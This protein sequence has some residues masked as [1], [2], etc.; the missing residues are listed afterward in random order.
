MYLHRKNIHPSVLSVMERQEPVTKIARQFTKNGEVLLESTHLDG[1][2]IVVERADDEVL[3]NLVV[4]ISESQMFVLNEADKYEL[5][6]ESIWSDAIGG[7]RWLYGAFK[8]KLKK[9]FGNETE[10]EKFLSAYK[11]DPQAARDHLQKRLEGQGKSKEEASQQVK[12]FV[13]S[14]DKAE[15]LKKGIKVRDVQTA[16]ALHGIDKAVKAGAGDPKAIRTGVQ[17]VMAGHPAIFSGGEAKPAAKQEQK[18]TAPAQVQ[19]P[20]AKPA[21]VQPAKKM[22]GDKKFEEG[23]D[24]TATDPKTNQI[25]TGKVTIVDDKGNYVINTGK[26][27]PDGK[28]TISL[29]AAQYQWAKVDPNAKAAQPSAQQQPAAQQPAA[30]QTAP[31]QPVPEPAK[32]PTPAVK[33]VPPQTSSQGAEEP[34]GGPANPQPAQPAPKKQQPQPQRYQYKRIGDSVEDGR[35]PVEKTKKGNLLEVFESI[36]AP[37]GKQ[38]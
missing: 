21:P 1:R 26:L 27:A 8:N 7:L 5:I 9:I 22:T 14:H 15:A 3:G 18:P 37:K 35:K 32:P 19:Q 6:T 23:D 29:P 11:Q 38:T 31:A 36:N 33:A 13:N 34:T 25:H 30:Q 12:Q 20:A 10:T 2:K 4:M 28:T 16:R 17:Q 24:V